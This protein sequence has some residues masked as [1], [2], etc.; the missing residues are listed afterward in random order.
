MPSACTRVQKF[1]KCQLQQSV[2]SLSCCSHITDRKQ[3]QSCNLLCFHERVPTVPCGPLSSPTSTYL[4]PPFLIEFLSAC[5]ICAMCQAF[6]SYEKQRLAA[7]LNFCCMTVHMCQ[8]CKHFD[9]QWSRTMFFAYHA[10]Y[11]LVVSTE[12]KSCAAISLTRA[13]YTCARLLG[14]KVG[15]LGQTDVLLHEHQPIDSCAEQSDLIQRI[16]T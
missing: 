7:T 13:C 6:D 14:S 2:H 4:T 10:P 11:E 5:A 8:T 1:T 3:Q 12:A 9:I 16:A 15:P